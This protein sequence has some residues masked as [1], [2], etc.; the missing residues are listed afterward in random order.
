[1]IFGRF[2]LLYQPIAFCLGA[3]RCRSAH[4]PPPLD[5]C[6]TIT[7]Y[8]SAHGQQLS[9]YNVNYNEEK[10]LKKVQF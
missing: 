4:E 7:Q 10:V 2:L 6:I 9:Y 1:M 3:L 8:E 5:I